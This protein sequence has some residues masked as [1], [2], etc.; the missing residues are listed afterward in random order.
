MCFVFPFKCVFVFSLCFCISIDVREKMKRRS[1]PDSLSF[2][3][4]C[5]VFAFECALYFHLYVFL[6]FHWC[7]W[8]DEKKKC[9]RLSQLFISISIKICFLFPFKRALYFHLNVFLY[10]HLYGFLYFHWCAWKDEKKKCARLT[11]L[12]A[13]S[14]S[15]NGGH[16]PDIKHQI[17]LCFWKEVKFEKLNLFFL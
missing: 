5:F 13:P 12:F 14:A 7:A 6:Y 2:S 15:C 10:F 1:V 11:Q 16:F 8:K 9:A 3:F 4:P 17:L